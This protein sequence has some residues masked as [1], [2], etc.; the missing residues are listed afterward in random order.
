[1]AVI[2]LGGNATHTIGNIPETGSQAPD[3][4]L[5][6]ND[7]TTVSLEDFKGRR[8][9]MNIFPSLDT[10]VCA[11]SVRKFNE[12][13]GSLENTEVLCISKDLPFAQARFAAA[14]GL[15]NVTN[16]SDYRTGNFGKDYGLT[17]TDGPFESLHSRVVIVL[18]KDHR[19]IY[20]EQ[21]PEIGQGPDYDSAISA[22][23]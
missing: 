21:V 9:I 10:G 2:T 13:G 8:I 12:K 15:E 18:D 7:L 1:M 5:V 17:I 11:S 4:K 22:L 23:R 6:K 20:S 14:E 19:I 16:L 3:F